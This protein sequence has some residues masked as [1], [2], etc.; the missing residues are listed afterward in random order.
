MAI[1]QWGVSVPDKIGEVMLNGLEADKPYGKEGF[2]HADWMARHKF[3][4][5]L[6]K[7]F[8]LLESHSESD[9]PTQNQFNFFS[10]PKDEQHK[11]NA[12]FNEFI[13]K[14]YNKE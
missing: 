4:E 5:S 11:F 6:S 2:L 1:K 3:A 8:G 7:F 10:V 9:R 13:K 14:F 12:N